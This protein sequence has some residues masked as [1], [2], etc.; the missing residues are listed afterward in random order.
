MIK[1]A[2]AL[3]TTVV[4]TTV[5]TAV[6]RVL[7][8][9]VETKRAAIVEIALNCVQAMIAHK[10]LSGPVFAVNHRRDPEGRPQ[11]PAK[12]G[13][14]EDEQAGGELEDM[15]PQA[16]AL[17]LLC[18]CDDVSDEVVERRVLKGL[19]TA[20]TSTTIFVHGQALLLVR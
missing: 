14:E 3:F 18:L 4:T 17:E 20:V 2:H 5:V 13:E 12:K 10:L 1:R 9:A 8:M 7:R 6:L 15:P 19:L 16:Q 11:T